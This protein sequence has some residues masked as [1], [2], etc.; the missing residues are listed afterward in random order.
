MDSAVDFNMDRGINS[1]VCDQIDFK[2]D[3]QTNFSKPYEIDFREDHETHS[4]INS[5]IAAVCYEPPTLALRATSL[6][7]GD[8]ERR[9]EKSKL[10]AEFE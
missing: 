1:R 3:H 8:N 4:T 2:M 6:A 9:F 10:R 7:G 5:E